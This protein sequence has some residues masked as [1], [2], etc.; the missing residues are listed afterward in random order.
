MDSDFDVD[1]LTRLVGGPKNA[2]RR[3]EVANALGV[4]D[5]SLYQIISGVKLASGRPRGVGSLLRRKLDATF[6]DWNLRPEQ[7]Q[8]SLR[9][10]LQVVLAAIARSNHKQ[11]LLQLLPLVV[12]TNARAYKLRLEELLA[13]DGYP[14][15]LDDK[16]APNNRA[17]SET[18]HE[19]SNPQDG[20]SEY[21][22]ALAEL[23]A[24]DNAQG[25]SQ[26]RAKRAEPEKST[27]K[28]SK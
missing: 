4:T 27:R 14:S 3:R 8:H 16:R 12:S 20:P 23:L 11:E 24:K 22:E 10:A 2:H 1:A 5:H 17:S 25:G 13:M 9:E 15:A 18:P 28:V 26:P 7:Q 19:V 21:D 6:P